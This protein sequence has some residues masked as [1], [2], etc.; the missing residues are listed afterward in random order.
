MRDK[1][2]PAFDAVVE[3][4]D[5]DSESTTSSQ[6][7]YD[8]PTNKNRDTHVPSDQSAEKGG[9][10][11]SEPGDSS[12][13]SQEGSSVDTVSASTPAFDYS[14][15]TQ[16]PIYAREETWKHVEDLKYYAEGELREQSGVRNAETREFDEALAKL[17]AEH[18]SPEDVAAAVVSLRGFEK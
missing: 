18:I 17:I 13:S 12:A 3:E 5:E 7:G 16:R 9:E 2:E 14:E 4:D 11:S 6:S 8:K 15:V 10:S 1:G